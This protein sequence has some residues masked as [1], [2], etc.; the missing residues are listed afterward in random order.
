MARF[1]CLL[2]ALPILA[3]AEPTADVET[4]LAADDQC[5]SGDAECALNALQLRGAGINATELAALGVTVSD[6]QDTT[7]ACDAGLVGKIKPMAPGCFA[8]CPEACTPLNAALV[9]YLTKGGMKAARPVICQHTKEYGCA[10]TAANILECE[11]LIASAANFGI[12]L[13]DSAATLTT[14]CG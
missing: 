3:S 1:A 14:F 5:A 13:P 9:M 4:A 12:N 11:K 6:L 10:L 7:G 8:A 2:L